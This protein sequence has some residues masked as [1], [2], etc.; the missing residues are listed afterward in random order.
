[1]YKIVFQVISRAI[2]Y[3]HITDRH[4]Y[5]TCMATN[6]N[7]ITISSKKLLTQRIVQSTGPSLCGTILPKI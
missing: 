2:S 1:M 5:L 3:R 7:L 4:P 6:N